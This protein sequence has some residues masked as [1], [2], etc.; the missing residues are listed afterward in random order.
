MTPKLDFENCPFAKNGD[1]LVMNALS[2]I[3]YTDITKEL[4]GEGT[5]DSEDNLGQCGHHTSKFIHLCLASS[6]FK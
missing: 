3:S 2:L 4:N 5:Q 6:T 1:S